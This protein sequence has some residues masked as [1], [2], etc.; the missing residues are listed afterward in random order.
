M[1]PVVVKKC[2]LLGIR[3]SSLFQQLSEND[4]CLLEPSLRAEPL[5]ILTACNH[6]HHSGKWNSQLPKIY[7]SGIH[8][9]DGTELSGIKIETKSTLFLATIYKVIHRL[10][11]VGPGEGHL[12]GQGWPHGKPQTADTRSRRSSWTSPWSWWSW[13]PSR[14]PS[15][16]SC[17]CQEV[18]TKGSLVLLL[19]FHCVLGYICLLALSSSSLSTRA[20]VRR[21]VCLLARVVAVRGVPAAVEDRLLPAHGAPLLL[22]RVHDGTLL[23][24]LGLLPGVHQAPLFLHLHGLAHL[25]QHQV[26][27]VLHLRQLLLVTPLH[28]LQLHLQA[29][30]CCFWAGGADLPEHV[31]QA[32]PHVV[33]KLAGL[34]VHLLRHR[35]SFRGEGGWTREGTCWSGLE[36]WKAA[37]HRRSRR[38]RK[39]TPH[40]VRSHNG[41]SGAHVMCE[42][43]VMRSWAW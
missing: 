19:L 40:Q 37:Q 16:T 39:L 28:L 35:A 30:D 36:I 2:Q 33:G 25:H 42:S 7:I 6:P 32:V 11:E 15:Q 3:L 21:P 41:R 22:L 17:S 27:V 26:G 1:A 23:V 18:S 43:T 8:E 5:R 38:P 31:L 9:Q 29:F 14:R 12:G 4:L 34:V 13:S 10:E 20:H 24:D